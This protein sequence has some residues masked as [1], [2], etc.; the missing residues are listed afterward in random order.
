MKVIRNM[1]CKHREFHSRLDNNEKLRLY[2]QSAISKYQALDA[3]LA[4]AKS[5]SKH[6]EQEAKADG[7]RIA[8]M[9]KERDD[10]K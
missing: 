2:V 7:E 8:W 1:A 4:K 10:A 5:K 3:S 9:G 6:W